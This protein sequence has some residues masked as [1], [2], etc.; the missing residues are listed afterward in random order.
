MTTT[1]EPNADRTTAAPPPPLNPPERL[2]MGPGPSNPDPRVLAAMGANPVGALPWV[3]PMMT[4]RNII[5][6]TTSV[7][8]QEPPAP[9]INRLPSASSIPEYVE[10]GGLMSYGPNLA[11]QLRR[12]ATYVDKIFK[13]AKPGDLPVEQSATFELLVNGKTAKALGITIPH[14][15]RISADKIIE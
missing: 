7:S 4:K 6:S 13:G 8:R 10:A 15:L 3:A 9:E 11:D 2:L 5:V 1:A 14:S 12:A